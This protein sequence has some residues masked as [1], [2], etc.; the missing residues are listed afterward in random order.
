MLATQAPSTLG[1]PG[2]VRVLA[3]DI[4]DLLDIARREVTRPLTDQECRR[5]WHLD[6]CSE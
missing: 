6:D 1:G 4:D 5:Y 2:I 3:L